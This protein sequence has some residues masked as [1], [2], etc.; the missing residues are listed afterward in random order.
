MHCQ[1][2]ARSDTSTCTGTRQSPYASIGKGCLATF[3]GEPFASLESTRSQTRLYLEGLS[4]EP[5][6]VM[7]AVV[8]Q[9]VM[10]CSL[11]MHSAAQEALQCLSYMH[12]GGKTTSRGG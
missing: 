5:Q 11:E 12:A 9:P 2:Q 6:H 4:P 10:S 8:S 7:S 1:T 3:V